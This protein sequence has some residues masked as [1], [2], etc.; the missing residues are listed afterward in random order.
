MKDTFYFSHDLNARN[1]PKILELRSV[2]GF[3]GYGRYWVLIEMMREQADYKIM[4]TQYVWN[5]L[6]IQL[7]C[8]AETAQKFACDCIEKFH[9]FESDEE[10]FWSNSLRR[11]MNAFDEKTTKRK[12]AAQKAAQARWDKDSK[13]PE[14]G[15]KTPK[16]MQPQC[17][18]NANAS[19]NACDTEC[20]LMPS[21][22][23]KSKVDISTTT[24][25]EDLAEVFKV[26]SDNIHPVSGEIE[27]DR[28]IELLKQ[29]GKTW[30]IAAVNR[31]VLRNKRSLGYIEGIL[32]GWDTNGFDDGEAN[33]NGKHANSRGS[34]KSNGSP[35][36]S[37][38][39]D[40]DWSKESNGW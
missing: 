11:R 32:K 10:A 17:E 38:K 15:K 40:A 36:G 8:D 12:A 22:V 24:S 37:K 19:P 28:L 25:E 9:L 21:K 18:D 33:G 7:Q 39:E 27:A 16:K 4:L 35:K 3:E 6:A 5:A 26:Y 13:Q 2:Y 34:S 30:M 31:A 14:K 1:D 29:F 23:E 20:D